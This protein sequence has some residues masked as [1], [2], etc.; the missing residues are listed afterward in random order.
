MA[1]ITIGSVPITL[2]IKFTTPLIEAKSSWADDW[3]AHPE[4]IMERLKINASSIEPS[5]FSFQYHYG[6]LKQVTDSGLNSYAPLD[7]SGWWVKVSFFDSSGAP[8]V[9][10]V[11]QVDSQGRD[12]QGNTTTPAGL[13]TFVATDGLRILE[14]IRV[15]QS[16]FLDDF[17]D[18]QKIGWIPGMNKRDRHGLVVGNVSYPDSNGDYY[19]GGDVPATS[20]SPKWT[21]T[22]YGYYLLGNFVQQ[23]DSTGAATGP[24]WYLVGQTEITDGMND[25]I[26]FPQAGTALELLRM[27]IEPK[28]GIDFNVQYS[29]ADDSGNA[30]GFQVNIFALTNVA[31][32]FGGKTMPA[33]PNTVSIDRTN[34]IDLTDTYIVQSDA[35]KVDKVKVIGQRIVVCGSL[36]G[37]DA[38]DTPTTGTLVGKWSDALETSYISA[39]GSADPKKCDPIRRAEK[40]RDVY[41]HLGAPD[42]WDQDGGEWSVATTA[43]GKLTTGDFQNLVRETLPWIPLKTGFDYTHNPPTD[44]TDGT[45][46][47][48]TSAPM[49]FIYDSQPAILSTEGYIQAEHNGIGVAQPH[50]DWGV[51]L[52]AAPNH[53]L[54]LNSW[55]DTEAM[56]TGELD[57]LQFDFTQTVATI[58]IESD[59]RLA[60]E[61]DAPA[62]LAAGDGSVMVI[63]V[64]EAQMW[65]ALPETIVGLDDTGQL[66]TIGTGTGSGPIILRNDVDRLSQ[67]MAGVISRYTNERSRARISLRGFQPWGFMVGS[68]LNA[69]QQGEDVTQIGNIISS[70][71]WTLSPTPKMVINSGYS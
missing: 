4:F 22:E 37:D 66:Q 64:E 8:Q 34:Q 58:A 38:V 57:A 67:I 14:K 3:S 28:Y 18:Q 11:G 29:P 63:M 26:D 54:A 20:S 30:E 69:F 45:T 43:E 71:E 10:F 16:I 7:L 39:G 62:N 60:I 36:F 47:A 52:S 70:I 15:S 1:S 21:R 19:Y 12:Y 56:S 59:H 61:W 33:N 35:R 40:Y 25:T 24:S 9:Q 27:L 2:P 51:F 50:M 49:V 5:S 48:E 23:S 32:T 31:A 6:H 68:V 41:Q 55:T 42:D 13:Q 46:D 53:R 65:V 17:G 44:N